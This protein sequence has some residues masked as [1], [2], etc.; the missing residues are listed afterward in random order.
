MNAIS[1][2][3]GK[4]GNDFD[5][6]RSW[7]N[8]FLYGLF[9]TLLT[10]FTLIN[11]LMYRYLNDYFHL[12]L[13]ISGIL[14]LPT[15]FLIV[16]RAMSN[17]YWQIDE[18]S[19]A[20]VERQGEYFATW[21]AGPHLTAPGI[22]GIMDVVMVWRVRQQELDVFPEHEDDKKNLENFIALSDGSRVSIKCSLCFEISDSEKAYYNIPNLFKFESLRHKMQGSVRKYA[23]HSTF[24]NLNNAHEQYNLP[25][26]MAAEK[27]PSNDITYKTKDTYKMFESWGIE[28]ISFAIS[29]I[30]PSTEQ[31]TMRE[32][33]F[34]AKSEFEAVKYQNKTLIS[35]ADAE[36]K[37][38][39]SRS[40]GYKSE[41]DKIMQIPGMTPELVTAT[42]INRQKFPKGIPDNC[43]FTIIEDGGGN[44]KN[45]ASFGAGM[46]STKKSA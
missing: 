40:D 34:K 45:G 23:A 9:F 11:F 33:E 13:I 25:T 29:A 6:N 31:Q 10:I 1:N 24:D 14:I 20:V 5:A 27:L 16:Y 38:M 43:N 41:F 36:K 26:I 2:F 3:F 7:W 4:I 30:I 28:P 18:G 12:T 8:L 37:A 21:T 42:V 19:E 44:A 46:N 39:I 15:Y 35:K 17:A 22:F 32:I